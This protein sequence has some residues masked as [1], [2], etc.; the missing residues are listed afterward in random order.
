MFA[1]FYFLLTLI[2]LLWGAPAAVLAQ[3]VITDLT[4]AELTGQV[5]EITP[6]QVLYHAMDTDPALPPSVLDKKT[7][8][9]VRFANGTREVF[10]APSAPAVEIAPA[11]EGHVAT[12]LPPAPDGLS[13]AQREQLRQRGADDAFR[14]YNRTGPFIGTMLGTAATFGGVLPAVVIGVIKPKAY[15]NKALDPKLLAYPSYVE[16]YEAKAR[17]RKTWPVI[18]GYLSGVMVLALILGA[19]SS[20]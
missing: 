14:Y 18:G 9:M 13:V 16:G 6:T 2:A 4:G 7:L 5:I 12:T 19:A 11:D 20:P 15:K 10:S 17:K 3:D 1:R 8:F